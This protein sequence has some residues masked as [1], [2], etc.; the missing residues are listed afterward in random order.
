MHSI[1][2][3]DEPASVWMLTNGSAKSNAS[4]LNTLLLAP[5]DKNMPPAK[6]ADVTRSFNINQ[7][8]IV[9][10][11]V[12]GYPYSE[13]KTPIVFG[14]VSDAWNANTTLHMPSNATIDIIMRIANDS[15]DSVSCFLSLR[16]IAERPLEQVLTV[17]VQ[18]G[19]PMHLHG[20]KFWVLG[21]GNGSFPYKTVLDAP[22]SI[23]NLQNPPFRDTVDVPPSGWTAI[24]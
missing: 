20:H 8:D 16:I 2:I 10:W 24:R 21:S 7:T 4:E 15:M 14:N 12:D 18:M 19:H 22:R 9:T 13:P 11:V 23:I 17:E 5:F 1:N 3:L 6:P